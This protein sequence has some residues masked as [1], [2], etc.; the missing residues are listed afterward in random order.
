M[1]RTPVRAAAEGLPSIHRRNALSV[2][3]IGLATV[4]TGCKPPLAPAVAVAGTDEQ[5]P[6]LRLF[7]EWQATYHSADNT[8]DEVCDA[9]TGICFELAGQMMALPSISAA[10]LAAK[11]VVATGYGDFDV[12]F[13]GALYAEILALCGGRR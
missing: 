10:D 2:A 3:G 1:T 13:D 12:D 7:H 5:S 9:L 8:P 11:L 4:L 6:V